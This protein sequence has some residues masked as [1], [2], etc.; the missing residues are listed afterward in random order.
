MKTRKVKLKIKSSVYDE[1]L[2]WSVVEILS[3]EY[4]IE[5]DKKK[6]IVEF[7]ITSRYQ[8]SINK[9]A[10]SRLVYDHLNNQKIRSRLVKDFGQL[11]E[12]I[13]SKA[14][15]STEIFDDSTNVILDDSQHDDYILD[16]KNISTTFEKK[17][18]K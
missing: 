8:T 11:R 12:M 6:S 5:L 7:T 1:H 13:V 10:I 2:I 16:S 14:L 9:E 3:N 18:E 4:I 15:F 17:Y